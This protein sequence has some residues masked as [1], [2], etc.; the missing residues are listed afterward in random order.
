MVNN[1]NL[2]HLY[3]LQ[4]LVRLTSDLE[5]RL[6]DMRANLNLQKIDAVDIIDFIELRASYQMAVQIEKEIVEILSWNLN[7]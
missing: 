7:Q 2:H 3:V 6:R 4:Y 5:N 1:S